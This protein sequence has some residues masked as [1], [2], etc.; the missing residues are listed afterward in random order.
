MSDSYLSIKEFAE[1]ANV[2]IQSVYK[3]I[4]KSDDIIH[5]FIIIKDGKKLIAA[6]AI[7]QIYNINYNSINNDIEEEAKE[8][9]LYNDIISILKEQIE[10]Q[11]REIEFK[12]KQIDNLMIQLKE[13]SKRET[14]YQTLLNQQQQLTATE[15]QKILQLENKASA[16][17]KKRGIFS[18]FR[19]KE[20]KVNE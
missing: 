3:R 19:K 15:K 5:N 6:A 18:F 14:N 20:E 4:K 9:P 8:E 1:C 16:N 12:N 7:E 11:K 2:S 10:Q 13:S 17:E